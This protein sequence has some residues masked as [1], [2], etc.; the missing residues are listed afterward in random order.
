MLIQR[1]VCHSR[2]VLRIAR[3]YGWLPGARYTNLRD[4]RGADR[5][6]FLDIDWEDYTFERHIEAAKA[7]RPNLT[8]ARDVTDLSQLDQTLDHANA[9]LEYADNVVV[10]PKDPRMSEGLCEHIPPCFIL[11]YSVPTQYAGTEI[12]I[13]A[14]S[15]RP[16]H[17]LGGRPDH[18]RR[19][20]RELNVTSIDTNRFTLDAA[21]GDYFD[22]EIF[23]PHPI[24]GYELCLEASLKNMNAL[25]QDYS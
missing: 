3:Q 11:G 7:T 12:P 13:H 10:V 17:L 25:W 6:G 9:L 14:F 22:G 2:R 5:L 1:Y 18:Q 23:R 16:V 4:V 20:A 19:L 21:Y 15:G 8:V 24:G